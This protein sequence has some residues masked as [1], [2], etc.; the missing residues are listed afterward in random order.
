MTGMS[1]RRAKPT[2]NARLGRPTTLQDHQ[3]ALE[4][5]VLYLRAD[6]ADVLLLAPV[7]HIVVALGE[8]LSHNVESL[9]QGALLRNLLRPGEKHSYAIQGPSSLSVY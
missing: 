7:V 9:V 2:S 6:I 4:E 3:V 5:L 8:L 1:A